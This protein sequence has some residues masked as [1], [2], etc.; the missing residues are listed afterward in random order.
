MN[1]K[2]IIFLEIQALC[3][4]KSPTILLLFGIPILYS[5]LFGSVYSNNVIKYVPTVIYDQ[6]QTAVSRALIQAYT[7]SERYKVVTQV[8]TQEAMEQSLRES[9]ALVAISIPPK[10]AQNIKLGMGS[11]VLI[12][13]NSTNNMFANTVISSSQEIIQTL[14]VATGQKLLEGINQ[15]PAQALRFIAPVKLGVR[16]MNNPTTSYT[17]FMLA[18]LMVNGLQLA[19][20]LVA[21]PLIAKEYSQLGHWQGTSAVSIIAGKLLSCWL[22]SMGVFIACLGAITV[23]F[24]VPFRGNPATILLLGSAFTFLVINLCFFFSSIA[25][26]EVSALQVPLLYIMPGLLF[27]GLSWPHLAMNDFSRVFSSLMPLTYIVDTLRDML[28]IGYSPTL[29]KNI[30]IMFTSGSGLCLATM[31]IFSQ[32]RKKIQYQL[33]KEVPI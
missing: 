1:L 4:R 28:L 29:L 9:E 30:F 21:G 31:F 20:L 13:T 11:E 27:S 2:E 22:C 14:S 23:F 7:D 19:I 32:R 10:F 5:F 6:D 26:N 3:R 18:G 17:N 33:A 16:I 8:T 25:R 24:D 15:Q 12:E